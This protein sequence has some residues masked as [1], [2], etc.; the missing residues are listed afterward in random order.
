MVQHRQFDSLRYTK[1]LRE[2]RIYLKEYYEKECNIAKCLKKIDS[3]NSKMFY[4]NNKI[5]LD[6][7][8]LSIIDIQDVQTGK[9]LDIQNVIKNGNEFTIPNSLSKKYD[10][11]VNYQNKNIH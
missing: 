6:S 9:H 8:V 4:N 5:V 3:K 7:N 2:K 10:I 11:I 1:S